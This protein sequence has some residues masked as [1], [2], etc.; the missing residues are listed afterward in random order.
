MVGVDDVEALQDDH[1]AMEAG[2]T[3]E[4]WKREEFTVEFI[5]LIVTLLLKWP[6]AC[7]DWCSSEKR[8]WFK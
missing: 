3:N 7:S 1:A 6:G 8:R 4:G 5:G 2:P